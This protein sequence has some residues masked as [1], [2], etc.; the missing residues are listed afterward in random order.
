MRG[1]SVGHGRNEMPTD[2]LKEM[3]LSTP[4]RS[5]ASWTSMEREATSQPASTPERDAAD[6][7]TILMVSNDNY[8]CFLH[9]GI[10][11]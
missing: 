3:G 1:R 11:N 2:S 9:R 6:A 4:P 7:R 10:L 8:D 5:T